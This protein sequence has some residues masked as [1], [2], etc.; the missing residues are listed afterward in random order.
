M[1]DHDHPTAGGFDV[2]Q[3]MRR[4]DDRRPVLAVDLAE[5]AADA[6]LGDNVESDGRLV[7]VEELRAVDHRRGDVGPDALA[8]REQADWHIP[9]LTQSEQVLEQGD[10]PVVRGV[11]D[12]IEL[13]EQVEG[14]ADGQVPPEL[15]PLAE[16]Q[17]D[18]PGVLL[19]VP[20]R[21][22]PGDG[23][24]AF[25]R[26]EDSG[27]HLDGAGLAGT[28][29]ADVADALTGL[30]PEIDVIDSRQLAIFRMEQVSKACSGAGAALGNSIDLG[31]ATRFNDC[32]QSDAT[33]LD[34]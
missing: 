13:L 4:Q 26:H 15:G 30:D 20:V 23:H 25:S 31:Q 12:A 29:R 21:Y 18:P 33:P 1:V 5:E 16:D 17:A 28:I 10:I 32:G 3:V 8:E 11:G 9:E 34:S 6:I 7:E 14:F 24:S 22:Q 19:T 27:Q 2:A